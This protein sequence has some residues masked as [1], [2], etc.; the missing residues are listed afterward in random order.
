LLAP[1]CFVKPAAPFNIRQ[2]C[3]RRSVSFSF[4]PLV[5]HSSMRT[6]SRPGT[7]FAP[8]ETRLGN[9][10]VISSDPPA[11][12]SH[13]SGLRSIFC[14]VQTVGTWVCAR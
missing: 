11:L 9:S 2:L 12:R 3:T 8:K 13:S 6:P 7:T 1:V 10:R 5:S 4:P 14:L